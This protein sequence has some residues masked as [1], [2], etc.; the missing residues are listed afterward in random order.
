MRR[1]RNYG[2]HFAFPP[3][4]GWGGAAGSRNVRRTKMVK[5][6]KI[7]FL[8]VGALVVVTLLTLRVTGLEPPYVDPSSE[9]F[10]KSSRTTRPGLWLKGEVV[11]EPVTN[12]DWVDKVNDPIKK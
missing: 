6:L 7:G 4:A 2:L 12:W 9:E 10:A 1:S 11:H 5:A 3:R 8:V